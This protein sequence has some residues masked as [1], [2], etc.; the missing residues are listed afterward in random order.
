VTPFVAVARALRER[1][2]SAPEIYAADL[3][4]GLL[5]LEDLG[6]EGVTA[7]DPP[8]IDE[9]RYTAAVEALAALHRQVL[10]EE[11]PVSPSVTYRIPRYDMD[12]FLIEAE[13]LLDWYLPQ[14]DRD[15]SAEMRAEFVALWRTTL[16]P[17]FATPPTW[18]LRD[19]HSP[20][21]MWLPQ[22]EGVARVGMLDFQDAVL[23]PAAYDVASLL[24][25]ARVD[26]S[27]TFEDIQI[28]RYM[29]GRRSDRDFDPVKFVELYALMGAQRATKILGIFARL[30]KR[31]GKPQYLRHQPRVWRNLRR[32]LSHPTLTSLKSWYDAHVPAPRFP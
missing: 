15:V 20:N 7:G 30:E 10:P 24:Q 27:A 28:G 5:I 8:L 25:D 31:D 21:L 12:A 18:V 22:R 6:G 1:G 32:S 13:L 19:Y 17:A 29:K 2:F 23:G 9:E 11:L 4:E 3:S 26:V 16:E 14:Q